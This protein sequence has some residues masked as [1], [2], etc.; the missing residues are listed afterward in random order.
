MWGSTDGEQCIWAQ[1]YN[2]WG[3]TSDFPNT[4]GVKS[5]PNVGV[6]L[7]MAITELGSCV[8]S[9]NVTVPSDGS[10]CTSYDIWVPSEIMIWMNW[11]GEVGPIAESWNDDGTP[12]ITE[13][14]V[15]VGGYTWN[16]YKG[17]ANVISF[18]VQGGGVTS[19]TVDIKAILAWIYAKGWISN[20]PVGNLQ[21]GFEITSAAGGLD[22]TTNNFS[23]SYSGGGTNITPFPSD[24]PTETPTPQPTATLPPADTPR[25]TETPVSSTDLGDVNND[26]TID[27]VDALLVAQCYVGLSSCPSA[28][29]GD[30]NCD[31]AIDIVDALLIAQYYVGL[32][33]EFC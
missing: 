8:S 11:H 33:T 5:Y 28:S 3:V 17:G 2:N 27:I 9:F 10:Y 29:I 20:G 26:G 22:F 16:V 6:S 4:S 32:I 23:L 14:D 7:D 15:T 12:V 21:F 13:P 19:G 31:G 18:L 24:A 30:T 1:A 25:P